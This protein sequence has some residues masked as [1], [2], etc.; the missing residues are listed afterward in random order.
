MRP[1]V[2]VLAVTENVS[3]WL[4]VPAAGETVSQGAELVAVQETAGVTVRATGPE[5][6]AGAR[7]TEAGASVTA[8]PDW[9]TRAGTPLTVMMAERFV[10]AV[11]AVAV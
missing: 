2:P 1:V 7:E 10:T 4:P 9:T 8:A 5:T 3:V 6:A 11:L